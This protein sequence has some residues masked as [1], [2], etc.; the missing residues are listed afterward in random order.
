MPI[1][2]PRVSVA[3]LIESLVLVDRLIFL[4]EQTQGVRS[5]DTFAYTA[6]PHSQLPLEH[7]G[8]DVA[9]RSERPSMSIVPLFDPRVSPRNRALVC[10]W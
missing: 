10:T 7:G 5:R 2:Y 8:T 3:P 4:R 9:G 6:T 1:M